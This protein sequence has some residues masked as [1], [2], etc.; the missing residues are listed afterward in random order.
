MS[1]PWWDSDWKDRSGPEYR[2]FVGNLPSGISESSLKD[3]FSNYAP[4]YS[5]VSWSGLV[6]MVAPLGRSGPRAIPNA[7]DLSCAFI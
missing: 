7:S 6:S 4:L 3:A 1:A 5:E 2:C